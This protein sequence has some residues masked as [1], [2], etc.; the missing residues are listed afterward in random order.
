[1]N[2]NKI[3]E[4]KNTMNLLNSILNKAKER[5]SKQK[6]IQRNSECNKRN[7]ETKYYKRKI[8]KHEKMQ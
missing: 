3:I 5:I 8:K 7:E 1:M 4:M 2:K 6:D